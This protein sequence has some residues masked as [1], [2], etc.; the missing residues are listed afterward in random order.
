MKLILRE[1]RIVDPSSPWHNQLGDLLVAD[2]KISDFGK[3]IAADGAEIISLP[4]LHV[5]PGFFDS[6][7]C[8]GE[9]GREE[10]G[11]LATEL[12]AAALSGFT[13]VALQPTGI[14]ATD[15]ASQVS[16]IL[17]RASGPGPA[18]HPIGN[19]TKAGK[20]LELAELYDMHVAGAVAFGDY[21]Q[22][23]DDANLL[24]IA[25]QYSLDFNALVIA[26][27]M[28]RSI[29]GK[30]LAHEGPVAASLGLRGIPALAEELAVARNLMLLEYAGGRLHI[31][32]IST[33]GSVELIR[34]AKS[35]GFDVSCS[36]SVHHLVLD[37]V[38]LEGFDTHFRVTPPL[39]ERADV[40]ALRQ[41]VLDGTIDMVTS[42]H[43]PVDI[44][45]KKVE[46][47]LAE[48]GTIGLESAFGALAGI[49]GVETTVAKLT[50]GRERF[51]IPTPSIASGAA[52]NLALF[53]PNRSW[54]FE[55]AHILSKSKNSAFV[56][57][58]MKGIVYGSVIGEN[59]FLKDEYRS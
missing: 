25:L 53:D 13:D 27:S 29:S 55:K 41:G 33:A 40:E 11:T 58:P 38:S 59:N 16:W 7:I 39:R 36:A 17:S 48:N 26:Y 42:D 47:A 12:R 57:H 20:G 6:G 46:F 44:E 23:L 54:A 56:G 49:F 8:T 22:H 32:T 18:V 45:H 4:N 15:N 3:G 28:D 52:A 9:P 14:P 21:N 37:E 2:G 31:P 30:G 24:K 19:L 51:G 5:S 35:R 43:N 10:R 50:A 34:S 1:S